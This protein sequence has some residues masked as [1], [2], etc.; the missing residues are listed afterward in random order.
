MAG[1]T[2]PTNRENVTDKEQQNIEDAEFENS[3][4]VFE[5][6]KTRV[7]IKGNY[8]GAER[9][10]GGVVVPDSDKVGCFCEETIGKP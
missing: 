4:P 1:P 9:D 8:G 5:D 6:G 7:I 3:V 2:E 10:V